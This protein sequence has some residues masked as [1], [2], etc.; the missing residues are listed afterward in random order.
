MILPKTIVRAILDGAR[1]IRLPAD[2][3]HPVEEGSGEAAPVRTKAHGDPAC[4]VLVTGWTFDDDTDEYVIEVQRCAAPDTP[5]LLHS[6]HHRP[7]AWATVDDPGQ[8]TDRRAFAM[9]GNSDPGEA[10]D[11]ATQ[12]QF[13]KE[14]WDGFNARAR[15]RLVDRRLLAIEERM[16][17]AWGDGQRLGIDLSEN[18]KQIDRVI[19]SMERKTGQ[20]QDAA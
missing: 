19:T 2:Y 17:L 10:V 15:Q 5:R 14:G 20:Q 9:G 12:A 18:L 7:P 6:S 1:E 4:W 11:P 13:T 8:Y 16:R 3:P